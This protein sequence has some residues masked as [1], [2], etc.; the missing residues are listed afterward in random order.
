MQD[1]SAAEAL[2]L[3]D[4]ASYFDLIDAHLPSGRDEILH[5]LTEDKL[6]VRQDNSLYAITNLG[7]ILFAKRIAA[8]DS[9]ARKSVRVIQYGGIDRINAIREEVGG[10][11]YANGF[12]GLL[13]YIEGLLPVKEEIQGAL[14]KSISVYPQIA[15]RELVANALIHQELSISGNG[16][17]IEIF[18]NRIEMTNPGIPL[19]DVERFI[20]NPPRSRNETMAALMRR[21]HICEER[22]SGWDKIALHCEMQQLPSP[23]IDV[24]DDSTKVTVFSHIPFRKIPMKEKLWSCYIH[25]CLKQTCGEQMTNSSLRTR[26]GLSVENKAGISRLISSAVDIELVKPLDPNTAPRYMSYVPYWA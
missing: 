10:K 18:D 4:Y 17:I 12:E 11:G 25:T 6:V 2:T 1:L 26:F 9:I 8:F 22:G 23:K 3:L 20:D 14:R 13:K 7:A 5:Y 19:V 24:Y 21:A 15:I 16:P